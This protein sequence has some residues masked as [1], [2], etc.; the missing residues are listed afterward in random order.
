MVILDTCAIIHLCLPNPPITESVL[1]KID[2]AATILSVSFAE[3]SCK[4][5]LGKLELPLSTA[6]LLKHYRSLPSMEI[7]DI[8]PELWI[9]SIEMNW[10]HNDPA[11]RMLVAAAM[12][13]KCPIVTSDSKIKNFYNNVLW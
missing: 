8:S 12:V 5:K 6:E 2:K 7:I 10:K 1:R 9:Q 4:I 11:D 13:K 3:I